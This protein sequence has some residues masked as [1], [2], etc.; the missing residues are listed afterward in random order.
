MKVEIKGDIKPYYVQSLIMLF[1]PGEKFSESENDENR[2]LSLEVIDGGDKITVSVFSRIGDKEGRTS[3]EKAIETGMT[4]SRAIKLCAGEAIYSLYGEMFGFY[5]EWG[6]MVGVRPTKLPAVLLREGKS[7]EDA[8]KLLMRD[9]HVSEK[10]AFL[11]SSTAKCEL[12]L[13]AKLKKRSCSLYVSIP[14]CPSRCSYC[15]FISYATNRLLSL[16][17]EYLERLVR[18]LDAAF[19]AIRDADLNIS[20]VYIGGGTPTTLSA[21]QLD[22]LLTAI[23]RGLKKCSASPLEFTLE[24]G[25]PDTVTAEKLAVACSHG[26]NRISVNPQTTSD[27]VLSSIGRSHTADDFFAAY[28]IAKKSGIKYINTDLIAGLPGD[29]VESFQKSVRDVIALDPANVTVHTF[30]V[31]KASELCAKGDAFSREGGIAPAC[32]DFAA[33]SLNSAGYHPYYMYRQKNMVGSLE[34]V[35]YAKEGADGLYNIFMMEEIHSII[36]VGA[37]AVTKFVCHSDESEDGLY[38]ERCFAPKYPYEYLE[39]DGYADTLNK[40]RTFDYNI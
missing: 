37:G 39:W 30:S 17:P 31:K 38:I 25:R 22:L 6:L 8:A 2:K 33:E 3:Y 19:D 27:S 5:P 40:I 23:N 26:V 34:N 21:S 14:F 20:T 36:A 11:A 28:D 16:I 10:K 1:F 13:I 4:R 18:D 9:F 29:T 32:V 35:G 15:S 24:A 7:V 12:D